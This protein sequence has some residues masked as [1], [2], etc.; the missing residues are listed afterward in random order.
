MGHDNNHH[1]G[2]KRRAHHRRRRRGIEEEEQPYSYDAVPRL[3]SE[4]SHLL[5]STTTLILAATHSLRPPNH[6]TFAHKGLQENHTLGEALFLVSGKLYL[7]PFD[8]K[9]YIR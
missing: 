1:D 7:D 5:G 3:T 9:V 8:R 6:I 2:E 4:N